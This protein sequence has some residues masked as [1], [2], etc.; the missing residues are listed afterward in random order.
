MSTRP[1]YRISVKKACIWIIRNDLTE[2]KV[3]GPFSDRKEAE[4][5]LTAW[6]AFDKEA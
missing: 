4:K 1:P 5:E 6:L 2:R 3:A